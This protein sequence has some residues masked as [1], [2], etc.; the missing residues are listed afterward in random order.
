MHELE[1]LS[2]GIAGKLALWEALR[3]APESAAIANLD[4]EVL[5]ERARSQ[6]ERVEIERLALARVALS[7]SPETPQPQLEHARAS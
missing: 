2:L 5:H 4:L 1:A 7:L 6:R 3:V